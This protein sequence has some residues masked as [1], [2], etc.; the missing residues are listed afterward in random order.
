MGRLSWQKTLDEIDP[1]ALTAD[2]NGSTD[3]VLKALAFEQASG[4]DV[5]TLR[6]RI[7]AMAKEQ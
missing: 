6:E 2:L 7:R 5:T 3:A 1:A 4:G